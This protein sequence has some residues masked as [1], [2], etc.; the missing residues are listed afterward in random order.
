MNPSQ[1][2]F[3]MLKNRSL[4]ISLEKASPQPAKPSTDPRIKRVELEANINLAKTHAKDAA[5][6]AIGFYAA[7]KTI[8]TLSEIAIN[9]APK[10]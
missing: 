7:V 6:G 2:G 3:A 1:K 10:N 8:K 5:I 4:K 9:I